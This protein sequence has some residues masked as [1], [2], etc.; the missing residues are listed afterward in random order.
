MLATILSLIVFLLV[1]AYCLRNKWLWRSIVVND[2]NV[3]LVIT[4]QLDTFGKSRLDQYAITIS[5]DRKYFS[6]L[7]KLTLIQYKP[8]RM[9]LCRALQRSTRP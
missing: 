4:K 7:Y 6:G 5:T 3:I 9:M 8:V 2:T 1:I